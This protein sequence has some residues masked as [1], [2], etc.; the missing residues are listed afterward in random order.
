METVL[1]IIAA[2]SAAYEILSRIIPTS[3][4]WSIV[5]LCLKGLTYISSQLDKRK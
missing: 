3:K 4:V 1:T 5:G 2:S